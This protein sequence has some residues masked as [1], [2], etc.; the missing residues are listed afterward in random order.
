M[1]FPCTAVVAVD[2]RVTALSGEILKNMNVAFSL[3]F[4][5]SVDFP[6]WS[7][8]GGLKVWRGPR[9]ENAVAPTSTKEVES[10]L[11]KLCNK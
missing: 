10:R 4:S 11:S 5:S 6:N 2:M 9:T 8:T 1:A 7:S 3:S